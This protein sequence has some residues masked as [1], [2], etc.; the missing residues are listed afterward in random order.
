MNL[1]KIENKFKKKKRINLIKE[2][3]NINKIRNDLNKII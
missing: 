2:G 1:I 3:V